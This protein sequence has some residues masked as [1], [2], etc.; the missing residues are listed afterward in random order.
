MD[1]LPTKTANT[2]RKVYNAY[3]ALI[4]PGTDGKLTIDK[5]EMILVCFR[6][7]GEFHL[8]DLT[9]DTPFTPDQKET[10]LTGSL[11]IKNEQTPGGLFGNTTSTTASRG[12]FG[13]TKWGIFFSG[14]FL[15]QKWDDLP[16]Y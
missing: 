13:N 7:L 3:N 6:T 14:A 12:L 9:T 1:P 4:G 2:Y 15:P 8:I 16:P 5:L 10:T 11:D